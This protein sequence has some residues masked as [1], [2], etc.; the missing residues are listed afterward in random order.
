MLK[1]GENLSKVEF[2]M[3]NLQK[4]I[5]NTC[6]VQADS[7]CV[8]EKQK[9]AQEKMPEMMEKDM[10]PDLEM[11]PVLYCA[12]GKATCDGLDFDKMCQCNECPIW[13]EY[14]LTDGEPM[15]YFCRDGEAL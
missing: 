1:R 9:K 12:T 8:K 4:C 5:C 13:K 11:V 3:E 2:N 7:E 15:G 6:P 14:N 10:M